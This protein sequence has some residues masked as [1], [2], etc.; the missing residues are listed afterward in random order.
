MTPNHP[1]QKTAGAGRLIDGFGAS[2]PADVERGSLATKVN[3]G[4]TA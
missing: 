2:D 1:L 3:Q 4:G